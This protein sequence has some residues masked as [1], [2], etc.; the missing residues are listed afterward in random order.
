VDEVDSDVH[1]FH[2]LGQ[3]SADVTSGHLDRGPPWRRVQLRRGP[4]Q[5]AHPSV[6][7]NKRRH[8]TATD[9]PGG[10]GDKYSEAGQK[11]TF[12]AGTISHDP[13]EDDAG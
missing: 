11:T 10:A 13:T 6:A 1:A 5:A 2:G 3:V 8:Q 9:V 7:V 12:G 4:G